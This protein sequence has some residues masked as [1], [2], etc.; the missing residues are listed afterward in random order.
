MTPFEKILQSLAEVDLAVGLML[1]LKWVY[2]AA[3]GIYLAFALIVVRQVGLMGKTL[4]G[5]GLNTVVQVVAWIHFLASVAVL[6]LAL[7]IL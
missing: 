7:G 3:L 1:I 4:D 2:V 5:A 6:L